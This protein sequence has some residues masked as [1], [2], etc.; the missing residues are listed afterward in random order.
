MIGER[1]NTRIAAIVWQPLHKIEHVRR[2][3]R[4]ACRARLNFNEDLARRSSCCG[5]QQHCH[6]GKSGSHEKP[7]F[8]LVMKNASYK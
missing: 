2:I 1:N 8:V 3:T 5:K 7:P 6:K 4:T